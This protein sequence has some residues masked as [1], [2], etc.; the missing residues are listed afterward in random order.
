METL[1]YIGLLLVI[2]P[3]LVLSLIR[4][5][6][7]VSLLD[8][9][10]R[11]NTSSALIASQLT[12]DVTQATQIRVSL[13]TFGSSP[14]ILIFL[15]ATGQVITIDRPTVSVSLPGGNQTIHRLRMVRGASPAFYLTDSDLDVVA[16]QVDTVRD[17]SSTLTG[18]RFHLDLATMNQSVIDPNQNARFVSD[19]T[20]DLQPQ[21]TQT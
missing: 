7:Q 6:K 21:T 12:S 19:F 3:P 5:T 9:R 15:D 16:W 2:L 18:L 11:L 8:V 14:S 10:N 4:I 1:I 17:R 20:V 13:S